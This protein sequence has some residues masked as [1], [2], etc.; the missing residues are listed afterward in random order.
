MYGDYWTTKILGFFEFLSDFYNN[1][2]FQR[3]K[4]LVFWFEIILNVYQVYLIFQQCIFSSN[5]EL[6]QQIK[7]LCLD[8]YIVHRALDCVLIKFQITDCQSRHTILTKSE[9]LKVDSK[10]IKLSFFCLMLT[11][12][13]SRIFLP[14]VKVLEFHSKIYYLVSGS[15]KY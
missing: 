5:T 4:S 3:Q 7:L 14:S 8:Y 12:F 1:F 10:I 15:I 11:A 6:H 13:F 9:Y 2:I